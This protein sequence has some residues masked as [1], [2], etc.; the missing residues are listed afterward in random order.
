[1]HQPPIEAA[2]LISATPE[3]TILNRDNHYL[4]VFVLTSAASSTS[5]ALQASF[6]QQQQQ[7][8][9]TPGQPYHKEQQVGFSIVSSRPPS[10]I[11]FVYVFQTTQ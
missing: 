4:A 9:A 2:A 6:W 1:M 11:I 3:A 10:I 7:Q 5:P 8:H